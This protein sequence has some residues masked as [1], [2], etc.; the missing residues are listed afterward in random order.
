MANYFEVVN[1]YKDANLTIPVRATANAAGYDLAAAEDIIIPSYDSLMEKM[2]TNIAPFCV[3]PEDGMELPTFDLNEVADLTKKLKTKPTLVSTGMKCHLDP[4]KYLELVV[5]SSSPLKY[6]LVCAN[7]V[8]VI[9]ADY[10]NNEDNEG[11]IFLQ[12]INFS[13]FDIKIKKGEKIAQG[14][15]KQYFVTENDNASAVRKGGFGSTS[16]E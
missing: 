14:I 6:W 3:T 8:G 15:I 7:S 2:W 12:V 5:R 13:P 1:K 16:N 9:D 11:E 4:D 10:Y